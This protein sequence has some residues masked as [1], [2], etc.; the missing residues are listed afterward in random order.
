[1]LHY[2]F[3]IINNTLSKNNNTSYSYFDN[4]EERSNMVLDRSQ[5]WKYKSLKL[6]IE[7]FHKYFDQS[8]ELKRSVKILALSFDKQFDEPIYVKA[9][10]KKIDNII[11]GKQDVASWS[12][13]DGI[14]SVEV[15]KE[16]TKVA[17]M[18]FVGYIP[19]IEIYEL[20]KDWLEFLKEYYKRSFV[21][22]EWIKE[23]YL[24]EAKKLQ[25]PING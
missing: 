22:L 21:P 17:D 19:T 7:L 8:E 5:I 14:Y 15:L 3:S 9:L 23:E 12:G 20:L 2:Y 4:N 10:L 13:E 6:N 11:H 24:E 1:M 18:N 25:K 16:M